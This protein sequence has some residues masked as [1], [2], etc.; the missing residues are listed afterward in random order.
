MAAEKDELRLENVRLR[1][2]LADARQASDEHGMLELR[3]SGLQITKPLSVLAPEF[4]STSAHQPGHVIQILK[5]MTASSS[6]GRH[7]L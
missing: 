1:D 2:Q 5:A 7:K 4:V 3:G 6:E